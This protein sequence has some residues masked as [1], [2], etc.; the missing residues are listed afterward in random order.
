MSAFGGKADIVRRPDHTFKIFPW[1]PVLRD[2]RQRSVRGPIR[3]L[4][5]LAE[6]ERVSA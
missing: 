2:Q 4:S 1:P 3:G 6:R 5:R